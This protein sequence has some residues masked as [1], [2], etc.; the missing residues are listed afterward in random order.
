MP[1]VHFWWF[2]IGN[3]NLES[4]FWRAICKL[5]ALEQKT[6]E[7]SLNGTI[8]RYHRVLFDQWYGF[9]IFT[10]I[11]IFLR[12]YLACRLLSFLWNKNHFSP[13]K[14]AWFW[15]QKKLLHLMELTSVIVGNNY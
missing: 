6:I 3:G 14:I 2:L 15:D 1:G 12:K 5:L 10:L 8:Q 11:K 9:R 7:N 13:K 4:S